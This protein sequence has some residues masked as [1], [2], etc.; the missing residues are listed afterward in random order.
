MK[1]DVFDEQVFGR[2]PQNDEY[3]IGT[4]YGAYFRQW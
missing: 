2:T 1:V 4:G 3:E